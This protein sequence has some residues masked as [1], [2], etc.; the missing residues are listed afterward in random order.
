M[1]TE[2]AAPST[3]NPARVWL[4]PAPSGPREGIVPDD[5]QADPR[6]WDGPSGREPDPKEIGPALTAWYALHGELSG[7]PAKTLAWA[8]EVIAAQL[9]AFGEGVLNPLPPKRASV[10]I[11]DAK[12]LLEFIAEIFDSNEAP[13]EDETAFAF[14]AELKRRRG[15][16]VRAGKFSPR[17]L[18]WWSVALEVEALV[19]A[20]KMQKVAVG[21]VAKRLGLKDT[22]VAGWVRQRRELRKR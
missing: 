13:S 9:D 16:P 8:A 17:S 5:A 6:L 11:D 7:D 22:V 19:K 18:G 12:M 15:R 2:I 10:A 20:G 4:P 1:G 21:E 3:R 14:K